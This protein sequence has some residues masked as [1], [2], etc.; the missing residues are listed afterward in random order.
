MESLAMRRPVLTTYIAG[1]PEL[2]EPNVNGWLVPAGDVVA[3]AD[4]MIEVLKTPVARLLE[5]GEAGARRVRERH[6]VVQE[7]AK[8]AGLIGAGIPATARDR[9]PKKAVVPRA[10]PR[11]STE[12]TE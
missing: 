6:D 1:I 4:A 8:L 2:V 12:R 3:L 11:V 9:A 10:A 7:A 5:M